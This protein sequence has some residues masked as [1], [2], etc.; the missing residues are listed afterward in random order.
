MTSKPHDIDDTL[1]ILSTNDEK[2]KLFGELLSHDTSRHI[3]NL[4]YEHEMTAL[5]IARKTGLSL[6][7]VRY[8][9]QKMIEI[10]IVQISKIEKNTKE[11]DM[12][13][14]RV[15]KVVIITLPQQVAEKLKSDKTIVKSL[16]GIYRLV[17]IGIA[18]A[19]SW[20]ISR[21]ILSFNE[22]MTSDATPKNAEIELW[23]TL[24]AF[25]I[26]IVGL[27]IEVFLLRKS[28]VKTTS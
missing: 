4:I 20:A 24:I 13:Y 2:I 5:E 28:T 18:S 17:C 10:G 1:E 27:S 6:E 21:T 12:K 19:A 26:I 8:H 23:P 25:F 22:S 3:L 9:V 14:Y 11:Q 15:S 16:N 7:L